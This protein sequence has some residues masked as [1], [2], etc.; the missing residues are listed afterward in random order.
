MDKPGK[1]LFTIILIILVSFLMYQV[2]GLIGKQNQG[3]SE[4]YIQTYI[5]LLG[6]SLLLLAVFGIIIEASAKKV[7]DHPLLDIVSIFDFDDSQEHKLFNGDPTR[8]SIGILV[9]VIFILFISGSA[10]LGFVNWQPLP[11]P[12]NLDSTFQSP[13]AD[14]H[15]QELAKL[16]ISPEEEA[17]FISGP[18]SVSEDI[19]F[20]YFL[21]LIVTALLFIVPF[22]LGVELDLK[23]YLIVSTIACIFTSGITGLFNSSLLPTFAGSH[24]DVYVTIPSFYAAAAYSFMAS[25]I[26][27]QIGFPISIPAHFAN[28]WFI[29]M[30]SFVTLSIGKVGILSLLFVKFKRRWSPWTQK[31]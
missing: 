5:I 20:N 27:V 9:G 16:S 28:N 15:V 1:F 29:T 13:L 6:L 12:I 11:G 18:V 24:S 3:W 4:K 22:L 14:G 21:P 25:W 31:S 26:N 2:V 23:S 8:I 30:G 19:V 7:S 10:A 17:Y